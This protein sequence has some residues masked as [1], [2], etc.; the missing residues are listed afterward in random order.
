MALP[1]FMAF[2]FL[3]HLDDA[4]VHTILEVFGVVILRLG[5]SVDIL[6]IQSVESTTLFR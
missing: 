4:I 3:L 5:Q 1:Y 2:G 6:V